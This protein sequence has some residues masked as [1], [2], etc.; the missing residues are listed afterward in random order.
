MSGSTPASTGS[1]R[2]RISRPGI[3]STRISGS[4]WSA[5][6]RAEN[7]DRGIRDHELNHPIA[8]D[9]DFAIWRALGNNAW[10]TKYLFDHRGQLINTWIGEGRYDEIESEVR[11]ALAVADPAVRLPPVSQEA[12]E[13]AKSGQPSYFGITGETYLGAERRER[14]A[15]TLEGDWRRERQYIELRQGTGTIVLPFTGGE[16]NLV[17][18]PGPSGHGAV[19]VWLDGTPIGEFR[20]ADVGAGSGALRCAAH[21]SSRRRSAARPARA[22]ASDQRSR[23]AGVRVHLRP[24]EARGSNEQRARCARSMLAWDISSRTA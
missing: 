8:I 4:S 24:L 10:P 21:D 12:T 15:V 11:R 23:R 20:G 22:D 1:V 2:C 16:V 13:F 18:Q 19:T 6:T 7:V 17:I 9:N 5:F 14:G 3:D